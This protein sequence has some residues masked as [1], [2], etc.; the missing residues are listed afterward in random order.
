M[1]NPKHWKDLFGI[2]I[3][4]HDNRKFGMCEFL[5]CGGFGIRERFGTRILTGCIR[6]LIQ[7]HADKKHEKM[8]RKK[9]KQGSVFG[10][11]TQNKKYYA[12]PE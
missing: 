4:N 11:C 1:S 5:F 2:G 10:I 3:I 9:I 8:N 7:K 6:D 12:S